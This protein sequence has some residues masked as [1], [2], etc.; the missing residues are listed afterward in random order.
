VTELFSQLS[1]YTLCAAAAAAR[2][3]LHEEALVEHKEH[4]LPYSL[5]ILQAVLEVELQVALMPL[6]QHL[7]LPPG[8]LLQPDPVQLPQE[9]A[10]QSL[11]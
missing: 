8:L 5:L 11:L 3:I 4:L 2:T 6:L 7:L 1:L 9:E 10:Q